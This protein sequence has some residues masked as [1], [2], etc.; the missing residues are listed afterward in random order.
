[1]PDVSRELALCRAIASCVNK[2]CKARS[3]IGKIEIG[4]KTR[5]D[6][7]VNVMSQLVEKKN[8]LRRYL[9]EIRGMHERISYLTT[10]SKKLVEAVTYVD[11]V[12]LKRIISVLSPAV[13]LTQ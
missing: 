12:M 6:S 5:F 9:M 3:A 4:S 13:G 2:S 11:W 8:T 1:M 10:K 7:L